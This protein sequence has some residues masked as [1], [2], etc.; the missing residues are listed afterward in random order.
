MKFKTSR[1][2]TSVAAALA[3]L[4]RF[5]L[6]AAQHRELSEKDAIFTMT[7]SEDVTKDFVVAVISNADNKAAAAPPRQ[8]LRQR[9]LKS[10]SSK[11]WGPPS[12]GYSN[13]SAWGKGKGKGK[14]RPPQKPF[15]IHSDAD[16]NVFELTG[17]AEIVDFVTANGD[18]AVAMC[19]GTGCI[20]QAL[21]KVPGTLDQW[22]HDCAHIKVV[23][24]GT[25]VRV[26]C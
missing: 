5:T 25:Q 8:H 2:S 16:D 17:K 19:D 9:K 13:N 14:G 6:G 11:G 3:L 22:D 21:A 24:G 23:L 15:T 1:T 18:D 20:G 4:G 7:V 26:V 12:K 10:K